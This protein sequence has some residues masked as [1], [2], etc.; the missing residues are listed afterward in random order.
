MVSLDH[1]ELMILFTAVL[2]LYQKVNSNYGIQ[3]PYQVS[4]FPVW[5]D[6][7]RALNSSHIHYLCG[8]NYLYM[9]LL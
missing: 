7:I 2:V 3:I 5:F 6:E 9:P 4:P 1:S 8:I